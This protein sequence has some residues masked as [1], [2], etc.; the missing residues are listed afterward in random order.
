M[1]GLSENQ[2]KE[3]I[4]HNGISPEVFSG[5][6]INDRKKPD[7]L[8]K[9]AQKL[10]IKSNQIIYIDDSFSEREEVKWNM[11]DIWTFDSQFANELM[12]FKKWFI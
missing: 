6:I 2:I 8:K 5:I 12:N 10:K 7:N 9:L 4:R 11:P 1:I 3:V